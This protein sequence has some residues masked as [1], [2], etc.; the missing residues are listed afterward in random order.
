M[1][2]YFIFVSMLVL[3]ACSKPQ[4]PQQTEKDTDEQ[5]TSTIYKTAVVSYTNAEAELVLN[6]EI[7]FDES[8]VVRVFPLVSGNVE[9]VKPQLGMYVQQGQELAVI[10]SADVTNYI[11]DYEVDKANLELAQ[12]SLQNAE[13]LYKSGFASETDYLTAK[14]EKEKAEQ[15]ASRSREVLRI[16]GGATKSDKPYFIVKAPIG[17]YIVEK[18]VNTGQELRPD[19]SEPLFVISNLKKVWVLANVYETDIASVKQGQEVT[20]KTLSY[21]DKTFTGKISNISNVLDQSSRV[22]KVR[23]EI[24]NTDGLLK[25]DMFATVHLQLTQDE[26]MLA[27]PLKAVVFDNDDYFVIITKDGKYEKRKVEILKNTS[28]KAFLKGDIKPGDTIVTEGS[29]LLFNELNS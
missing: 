25:P 9:T 23:V 1:K 4:A 6:G 22:M 2:K 17:G 27:V 3:A 13:T 29:L 8:N 28:Q 10:K 24:E 5:T 16:Y 15:E 7:S 14:K 26:K 19:N 18:N 11:K 12:K 20:I 21:P